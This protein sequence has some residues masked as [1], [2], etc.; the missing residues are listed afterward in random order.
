VTA[1]LPENRPPDTMYEA[2][3]PDTALARKNIR[4]AWFL[5]VLFLLLFGGTFLVGLAYL[6]LS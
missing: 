1:P 6:W 5:V 4:L 2:I 3:E